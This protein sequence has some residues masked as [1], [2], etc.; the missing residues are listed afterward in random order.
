MLHI[1]YNICVTTIYNYYCACSTRVLRL[2]QPRFTVYYNT[3]A[4]GARLLENST[5]I[6]RRF[7]GLTSP[8][9]VA[10]IL[11]YPDSDLRFTPNLA[12]PVP[13]IIPYLYCTRIS[14]PGTQDLILPGQG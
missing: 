14:L 12:L 9:F 10:P 2:T 6:L 7:L 3:P 8:D 13:G 5:R 1:L 4:S 11:F